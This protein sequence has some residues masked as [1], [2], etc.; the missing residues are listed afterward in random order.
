[1]KIV[2][3]AL[4]SL[5]VVSP[6]LAQNPP[7]MVDT[8][9]VKVLTGLT[10]PEFEAEM[11]TM[12]QALGVS[13]GSCHVR[14]NFAADTNPR[15]ITARRM[16]EMTKG[17]NRQFFPDYVPADGESRMGRVTCFTCHQGAERPKTSG[18]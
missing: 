15:K 14:G 5:L 1:M 4:L 17:I 6:A 11:Q 8:P 7:A 18:S 12:T 2:V 9:T 16:I 3:S 13:C 10:V